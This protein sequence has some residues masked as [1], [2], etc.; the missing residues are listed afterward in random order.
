MVMTNHVK[1]MD[2]NYLT[3]TNCHNHIMFRFI[4]RQTMSYFLGYFLG[5]F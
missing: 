2:I 1:A 4:V 3:D 5:N